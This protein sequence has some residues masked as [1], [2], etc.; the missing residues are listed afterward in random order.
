MMRRLLASIG[1]L[2]GAAALAYAGLTATVSCNGV[3]VRPPRLTVSTAALAFGDVD[4]GAVAIRAFTVR[5]AG[6]GTLTGVVRPAVG[7]GPGYS[8]LLPTGDPTTQVAYSLGAGA[9]L[10]VSVRFAPLVAGP[11]T[12]AFALGP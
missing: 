7:C 2:A 12:C 5:N 8:L 10:V 11:Q 1:L 4:S 3:G 9:E 6:G